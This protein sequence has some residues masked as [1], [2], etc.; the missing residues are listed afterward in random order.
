MGKSYVGDIGTRIRTTLNTDLTNATT[1]EYQVEKPD[2][3]TDTWTV[4]VEDTTNGIV[5]YDVIA[6]D[7][8]QAGSYDIQTDITYNDGDHF[9][10][11]TRKINVFAAFD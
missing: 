8:D 1:L 6:G 7:F 3:T 2:A 9:L 10:S 4:T 5:Y 11:E